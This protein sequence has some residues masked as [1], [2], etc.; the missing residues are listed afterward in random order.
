MAV[1][2]C[3]LKGRYLDSV[4]LMLISKE[5]RSLKG[6]QDAVVIMATQENREILKS[7][8]M[9]VPEIEPALETDIVAV[10]KADDQITA[11]EAIMKAESLVSSPPQK[12]EQD[13]SSRKA[14][15]LEKANLK[16]NGADLCLISVAGKYA[17]TEADKAL[18]LGLHVMLFSDN[19]SLEEEL[20]LK[21][22]A[23]KKGLLMMG[24]DCGTAI[25]NGIPLAFANSVP[26][27]RIGIVSA[28]GTGLQEISAT[29]ANLGG[30]ISQAFG[31]GGRDGKSPIGG[32]MLCSCLEY[33]INDPETEVIVLMGKTP[34]LEVLSKLWKLLSQT[35]KP[36][37]I[38]FLK[39]LEIPSQS[40]LQYSVSLE[41]TARLACLASGLQSDPQKLLQVYPL[42][43]LRGKYLRGL[44][45]GGTLCAEGLQ[46]YKSHFGHEPYSNV[47]SEEGFQLEDGWK[48]M[49]D[50]LID[51]GSDEF[52]VGRP[53][54][55]I[56][57]SLRLQKITQEAADSGVGIIFLDV[58]LGYGANSDPASELVPVL[59]R[60]DKEIVVICHVLGTKG[61]PQDREKQIRQLQ[62]AGAMVFTSHHQAMEFACKCLKSARGI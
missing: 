9:L 1:K 58:V 51:L 38:N 20:A 61:D 36:V 21:T 60:L 55:M 57:Y 16:L 15:T 45:S 14:L 47:S 27:G 34:A 2:A 24:P 23:S 18:E 59:E 32:L 44:Y 54:P 8:N 43:E 29:I 3:I 22:K 6:V 26:R 25:I 42:P 28:S 31:T 4:K 35:S 41:E 7:T 46:V 49:E 52:T 30:G 40:N 33:L 13:N 48:T 10:V 50:S 19:V 11:D 39:P 12:K 62:Q 17:A 56:D 5:L 53:H 37:I